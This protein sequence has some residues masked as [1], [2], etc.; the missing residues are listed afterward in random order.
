VLRRSTIGVSFSCL[1]H[2]YVPAVVFILLTLA[3]LAAAQTRTRNVLVLS[4]GRGRDSI[5]RMASSLRARF[6]DPVNFSIVDLDNPRFDQQAYQDHLADAL[7]SGYAGEQLDLVLAVMTPSLEFAV[8]YRERVFPGVPVVFMSIS[9]PLPE[10]MWP[11]VTGVASPLGV[12]EI[13]N[14][15]LRLHPD[16]ETVAVV[17]NVTNVD[18]NWL[19]AERAE[20]LRDRDKVREIDLIGP[21][22]PELLRKVAALPPHTVVL[23]QLFPQ[24]ADQLAFGAYDVLA[25][26]AQRFPTYSILSLLD[27]GAIGVATYDATNDAVLA[28]QLAARVLSGERPDDIPMVQNSNVLVSVDWRQL[29]RWNIPESALPAGA[30]IMYRDPT[31]WQ[32]YWKY[33]LAAS[34]VIGIQSFLIVGLLWQRQRRRRAES[35][36]SRERTAPSPGH[37]HCAGDDLDVRPG[38]I[39]Q[40]LQP[41][42][43]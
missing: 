35:V 43:A 11:G 36:S 31:I 10:K 4:G 5:N 29:R 28:G 34:A 24:D 30:R 14:L 32:R 9:S 37:Q 38:E 12:T 3:P 23:F 6:S 39:T 1:T 33:I 25:P 40:L 20:L 26:V 2:R 27:R 8:K 19:D 16:T 41:A 18:K 22:S 21:P 7:R 13:I 17:T 15:A 42:V